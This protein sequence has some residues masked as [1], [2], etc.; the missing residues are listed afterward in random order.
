MDPQFK[1]SQEFA[2]DGVMFERNKTTERARAI[3]THLY[4]LYKRG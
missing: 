4:L 3:E 2:L 1:N